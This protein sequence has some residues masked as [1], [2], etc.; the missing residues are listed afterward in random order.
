ML[1]AG[2]YKLKPGV[3]E[4]IAGIALSG[5]EGVCGTGIRSD[6]AEDIKKRKHITKGI[7]AEVNDGKVVLNL[8]VFM[9]YGRDFQELARNIQRK[10][11]DAIEAMTDWP[12]EA[13]NVNVVGV[14]AL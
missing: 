5:I 9:D 14:N 13:V 10:G 11:K 12:V 1:D 7:K 8:E 2:S 6:H 4:L 3:L